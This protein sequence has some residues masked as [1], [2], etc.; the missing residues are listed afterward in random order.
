MQCGGFR[1]SLAAPERQRVPLW[2][3]KLHPDGRRTQSKN[4]ARAWSDAC[5]PVGPC[6]IQKDR[7][8]PG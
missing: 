1:R 5:V 7:L 6:S 8:G 4:S 3:F 2:P